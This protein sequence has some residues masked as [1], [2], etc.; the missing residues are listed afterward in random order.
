M[1]I[2]PKRR[3]G[4]KQFSDYMQGNAGNENDNEAVNLV[5]NSLGLNSINDF[6]ILASKIAAPKREGKYPLKNPI[7][8]ISIR[9]RKGD[10][11]TPEAIKG[12]V[13]E[14]LKKLGYQDCPW[15]LVQHIKDGE[16]HYHLGIVRIDPAGNAN[17]SQSAGCV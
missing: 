3:G 12:K 13:P 5:S 9:T 17:R 10:I 8:H 14:L 1:I 2:K 11:L 6:C 7:E 15:V 16:P 4:F